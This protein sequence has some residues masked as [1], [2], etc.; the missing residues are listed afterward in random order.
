GPVETLRFFATQPSPAGQISNAG[1]EERAM[2]SPIRLIFAVPAMAALF[3]LCPGCGSDEPVA[4]EAAE[5]SAAPSFNEINRSLKLDDADAAVVKSALAEWKRGA[6]AQNAGA[7][8]LAPRRQEM[9]FVATV[10]PSLDDAQL[11]SLVSLLLSRREE[12][13]SDMR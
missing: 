11:T 7:P 12:R 13:R 5:N 8:G 2:K 3:A 9:E 10:A 6:N 4:T 1:R